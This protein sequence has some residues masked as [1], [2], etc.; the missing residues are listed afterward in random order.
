MTTLLQTS[1]NIQQSNKTQLTIRK[2][3]ILTQKMKLTIRHRTNFDANYIEKNYNVIYN[4]FNVMCLVN[5]G[6]VTYKS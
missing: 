5:Y 2:E 3:T 1:I 4:Q 6:T